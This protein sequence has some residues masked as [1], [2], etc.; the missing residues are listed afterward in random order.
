MAIELKK[1]LRKDWKHVRRLRRECRKRPGL[2]PVHDLR[3]ELRRLLTLLTLLE[4]LGSAHVTRKT[5]KELKRTLDA[6]KTL[7]DFQ[8]QERSLGGARPHGELLAFQRALKQKRLREQK[9]VARFLRS[10][11]PG[12][13]KR[14]LAKIEAQMEK[15]ASDDRLFGILRRRY[16]SFAVRARRARAEDVAKLHQARIAFKKFRYTWDALSSAIPQAAATKKELKGV[17]NLLGEH[18]DLV[19][20]EE[21]LVDFEG[22]RRRTTG[23]PAPELLQLLCETS[24]KQKALAAKF[25]SSRS[26][27]LDRLAPHERPKASAL[28]PSKARNTP[29]LGQR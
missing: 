3:V 10:A 9:K 11:R 24:E 7:R 2:G 12:K 28:S 20:L 1:A 17:Q 8:I 25:I 14:A 29:G 26:S 18:Q 13:T 4:D 15:P 6:L 16:R 23:Y 22:E 5:R 19:V 27:F 21:L